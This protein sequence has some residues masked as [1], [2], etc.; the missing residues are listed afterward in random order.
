MVLSEELW[1][2]AW[3]ASLAAFCDSQTPVHLKPMLYCKPHT[4]K[5][6]TI[7]SDVGFLLLTP[8]HVR[9]ERKWRQEKWQYVFSFISR[10]FGKLI[11][12]S[13]HSRGR[14]SHV[15]TQLSPTVLIAQVQGQH[16]LEWLETE[17]DKLKNSFKPKMSLEQD[18]KQHYYFFYFLIMSYKV[19]RW[20]KM[21]QL[22]H[23]TGISQ[24]E[25]VK[26]D[27]FKLPSKGNTLDAERPSHCIWSMCSHTE[28]GVRNEIS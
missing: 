19:T 28:A 26:H 22:D 13:H 12:M 8:L 24:I 2:V 15:L 14:M 27:D 21:H 5:H 6:S 7:A 25:K 9:C 4:L 1:K 17:A 18:R 10:P 16:Y 23:T 20:W 11:P 3:E